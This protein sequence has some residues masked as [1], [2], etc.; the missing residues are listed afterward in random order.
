M[1]EKI[2]FGDTKGFV[3][4]LMQNAYDGFDSQIIV[5]SKII[6]VPSDVTVKAE[7]DML[8]LYVDNKLKAVIDMN[9]I[10]A[11]IKDEEDA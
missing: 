2:K 9:Q 7:G 1:V 5:G 3:D 6:K 8:Q 10:C 4:V 11:V